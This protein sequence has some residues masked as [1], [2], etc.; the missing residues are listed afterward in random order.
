[1]DLSPKAL[2]LTHACDHRLQPFGMIGVTAICQILHPVEHDCRRTSPMCMPMCGAYS[3]VA[4]FMGTLTT[5]SAA[6][7][8]PLQAS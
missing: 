6:E 2:L 1:M 8:A 4:H 5:E 7:A 3:C